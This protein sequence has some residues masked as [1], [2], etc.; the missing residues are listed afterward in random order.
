MPRTGGTGG[1]TLSG[2]T[3]SLF[4]YAKLN[5]SIWDVIPQVPKYSRGTLNIIASQILKTIA[6][7]IKQQGL[8]EELIKCG[9]AIYNAGVMTMDFNDDDWKCGNNIIPFPIP[10][11]GSSEFIFDPSESELNPQPLPPRLK[12]YSALLN[13]VADTID[14]A[15]ITSSLKELSNKLSSEVE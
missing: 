4:L 1:G 14:D 13:I 8:K 9:L 12:Y 11:F 5:P 7:S 15:S 2:I 6:S 3:F 10:H